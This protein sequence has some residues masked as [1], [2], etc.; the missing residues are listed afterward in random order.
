MPTYVRFPTNIMPGMIMP[1]RN[2]ALKLA[3][4]SSSFSTSNFSRASFSRPYT[5]TSA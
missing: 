3:S 1:E 2:W 5:F 4:N